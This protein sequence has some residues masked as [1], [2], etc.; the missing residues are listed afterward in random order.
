MPESETKN[1]SAVPERTADDVRAEY[2]ALFVHFGTVINFC[3]RALGFFLAA[4]G[5]IVSADG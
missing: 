3:F 5:L 4:V 1:P 2:A